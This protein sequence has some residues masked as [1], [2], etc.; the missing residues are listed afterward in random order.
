VVPVV[1]PRGGG[2]FHHGWAWHGSGFNRSENPRR[3]LVVHC[4]SSEASFSGDT[5]N[6]GIAPI[7][8]RYQRH[9]DL[10]M[11]ENYFPI[12]WTERGYRTAFLDDYMQQG[13]ALAA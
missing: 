11:D 2:A 5:S 4:I 13:L 8:R 10:T 12:L 1:V 9:G 7:Y 6:T 3:S